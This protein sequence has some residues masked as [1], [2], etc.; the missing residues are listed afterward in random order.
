M[1]ERRSRRKS[2]AHGRNS[3]C[4]RPGQNR[5][6]LH[7]HPLKRC[8]PQWPAIPCRASYLDACRSR[9]QHTSDGRHRDAVSSGASDKND[10]AIR[11]SRKNNSTGPILREDRVA[12]LSYSVHFDV[13]PVERGRVASA[14]TSRCTSAGSWRAIRTRCT[15]TAGPHDLQ[16]SGCPIDIQSTARIQTA[17]G[18]GP[19]ILR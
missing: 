12:A 1:R 8:E 14:D 15:G 11:N 18:R 4:K 5:S 6:S 10:F 19:R 2:D 13:A 7:C 17:L 16:A 9:A 3:T